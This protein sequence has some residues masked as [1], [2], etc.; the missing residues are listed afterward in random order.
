[1]KTQG[2]QLAPLFDAKFPGKLDDTLVNRL[3]KSI[4]CQH[5]FHKKFWS[6]LSNS[7]WD[8]IS[9]HASRWNSNYEYTTELHIILKVAVALS[10]RY[11]FLIGNVD[12]GPQDIVLY[13]LNLSDKRVRVILTEALARCLE[14]TLSLDDLKLVSWISSPNLMTV[15][16]IL[17]TETNVHIHKNIVVICAHIFLYLITNNEVCADQQPFIEC[18]KLS[19]FGVDVLLHV[20]QLT[21]KFGVRFDPLTIPEE[22]QFTVVKY[23]TFSS[24]AQVKLLYLAFTGIINTPSS[25]NSW[26]SFLKSSK[27]LPQLCASLISLC[28]KTKQT[29]YHELWEFVLS[30]WISALHTSLEEGKV[31]SILSIIN[32][33]C[34]CPDACLQLDTGSEL[35]KKIL[36]VLV[37]PT[38]SLKGSCIERCYTRLWILSKILLRCS[39]TLVVS[40][41]D[42]NKVV[43]YL[44]S[45]CGDHLT[46]KENAAFDFF[47][48][49]CLIY[50]ASEQ[51]FISSL[52]G[53]LLDSFIIPRDCTAFFVFLF[54]TM[55]ILQELA[56]RYGHMDVYEKF[57]ICFFKILNKVYSV[58]VDQSTLSSNV[59]NER[60]LETVITIL[61]ILSC[62]S[63]ISLWTDECRS[64]FSKFVDD[65]MSNVEVGIFKN[66]ACF[67][68]LIISVFLI[69]MVCERH[70]QSTHYAS[71]DIDQSSEYIWNTINRLIDFDIMEITESKGVCEVLWNAIEFLEKESVKQSNDLWKKVVSSLKTKWNQNFGEDYILALRESSNQKYCPDCKENIK[72]LLD[73]IIISSTSNM[74]ADCT[75]G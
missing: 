31:D 7:E 10:F 62:D 17:S 63:Y 53:K 28:F 55:Q 5:E 13:S 25:T 56:L 42:I 6:Q 46:S 70:D 51:S 12:K 59:H 36:S 75:E 2:Y 48:E 14:N 74:I 64:A 11:A 32:P 54:P 66:D 60:L 24:Q 61:K 45:L 19:D 33:L 29:L 23:N 69:F 1:M 9:K 4:V 16:H 27:D 18:F 49:I 57:W 65:S 3:C 20:E 58:F 34:L 35:L 73:D 44:I 47:K 22:F 72:E 41:S 43:D 71:K 26:I 50:W 68:G 8:L 15:L 21:R 37:D 52:I 39:P 38:Y 30:E 40:L 67:R